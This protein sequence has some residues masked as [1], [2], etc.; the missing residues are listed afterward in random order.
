[1]SRQSDMPPGVSTNDI[2]GNRPEDARWEEMLEKLGDLGED[3]DRLLQ[4]L[5]AV[6][7][8]RELV[9]EAMDLVQALNV[10]L[11]KCRDAGLIPQVDVLEIQSVGCHIYP[12]VGLQL[13]GP[14]M[15]DTTA[16]GRGKA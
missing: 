10:H 16:K 13:F 3:P 14:S 11:G 9:T 8:H 15:L 7:L 6:Q 1:M 5:E 2:P 4:V 12:T